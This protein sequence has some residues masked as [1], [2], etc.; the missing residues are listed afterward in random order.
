M[1]ISRVIALVL[2]VL[3]LPVVGGE[4][5]AVEA[6]QDAWTQ[7]KSVDRLAGSGRI[8]TAVAVS[9]ANWDTADVALLATA[10]DFPD[11]LAAGALAAAE[12]APLLLSAGDSL[13]SVVGSE[14]ERLGAAQVIILGGAAAVPASVERDV[15]DLGHAPSVRRLAGNDRFA[16]AQLVAE[17]AG[18]PS[19]AVTVASGSAFPDALSAASLSAAPEQMPTLL[20]MRGEM[21]GPTQ[22]SLAGL[23]PDT[24][25]VI[26]GSAAVASPVVDELEAAGAAV[27]RLSGDSRF[28]T[29]QAVVEDALTRFDDTPRP[30]LVATGGDYPDAL[31]AG[32]MAARV[33]GPLLLVP[34]DGLTPELTAYIRGEHERFSQAM[35][36]GGTSAVSDRTLEQVQAA[37]N[38]E[39]APTTPPPD[40]ETVDLS[41]QL[42]GGEREEA[43]VA[44]PRSGDAPGILLLSRVP[45]DGGL[46]STATVNLFEW[47]GEEY[48]RTDA[49]QVGCENIYNLELDTAGILYLECFAG[50][51]LALANAIHA[52]EGHG[53]EHHPRPE[54]DGFD[55]WGGYLY[56]RIPQDEGPD[57]LVI[58][59]NSCEPSCADGNY[60]NFYLTYEPSDRAYFAYGA[61]AYWGEW[62]EFDPPFNVSWEH[63]LG[64]LS[65]ADAAD[66]S[67]L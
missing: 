26:G 4:V 2:A 64:L 30:L 65:A 10:G 15:R 42:P 16:T 14:L 36:I 32:A 28:A 53:I 57:D 49:T 35:V 25:A 44:V 54:G 5:G 17:E 1:K 8:E 18:A 31:A 58:A 13:P 23:S 38:D 11:A 22:G 40:P 67:A 33:E 48:R 61:D 19:G 27:T 47:D 41:D 62:I 66:L 12:D 56:E 34:G 7:E 51:S 29:S 50:A 60:N 37:I 63:R 39:D 55:G 46:G 21:P 45:G 59:I 43:R 6:G 52:P 24:A 20:T 9:Q 3:L